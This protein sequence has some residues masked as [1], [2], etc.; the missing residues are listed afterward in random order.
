MYTANTTDNSVSVYDTT[1][2]LHPIEIQHLLLKGLGN[3]LQFRLSP[4]EDYLYLV[5]QRA[6]AS[7][8]LG[9]GNTLHVLRINPT[10]GKLSSDSFVK[11]HL[12]DGTRPQGV[13]AVQI[14]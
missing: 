6:S 1:D 12:P 5:T 2:P 8:P 9:E 10:S 14:K 4:R 7:I 13:A 11:L 3:A